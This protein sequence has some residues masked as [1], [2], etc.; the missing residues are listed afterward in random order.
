MEVRGI[1]SF[2]LRSGRMSSAQKRSYRN[3]SPLYCVSPETAITDYGTVF[4]NAN[5]VII[6]IGFGSGSVT[7]SLA[8]KNPDENYLGIEVFKA[9]IGKLLWE[10]EQRDLIN[11]RIIEG[12]AVPVFSGV[13]PEGGADGCHIFFPDPWPKKRH[14]KRRLV[15]RPFTEKIRDCLKPHGYIYMVTDWEDYAA[16]ALAE[17]NATAALVNTCDGFAA[18]QEWRPR[19]RFEAKGL[20]KQHEVRELFFE[21]R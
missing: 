21:K 4:G 2:V 1:K 15:T 6:E 5:P 9:G 7:A 12:D 8:E 13:L 20:A 10:I 3:L 14:H 18:P 17:L 19:T 16:W 11:I